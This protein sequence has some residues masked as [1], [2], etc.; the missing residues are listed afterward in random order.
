MS[1]RPI[2]IAH[3]GASGYRPEH[4]RAAY[5]LALA[6]GADAVE[7]DLVPT[8]DGVLVIRHENEISGTTDVASRAEFAD[9]RTIKTIEGETLTGWFTEDFTWDELSTLR[10]RER[11]AKTRPANTRYDGQEG[12]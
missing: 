9:R 7:P 12:I 11:L 1:T 10:A 3:R 2:V 8:R 6:Q 4:T 5:E